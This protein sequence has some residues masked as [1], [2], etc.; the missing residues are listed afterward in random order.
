MYPFNVKKLDWKMD[1]KD[2]K[3]MLK[4]KEKQ[5]QEFIMAKMGIDYTIF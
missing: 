1:L 5:V 3:E 4:T 2:E